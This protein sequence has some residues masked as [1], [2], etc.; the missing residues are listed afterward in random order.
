MNEKLNEFIAKNPQNYLGY[1]VAGL[2][3][4]DSYFLSG[5]FI[6]EFN[7]EKALELRKDDK[8]IKYYFIILLANEDNKKIKKFYSKYK[9][10]LNEYKFLLMLEIIRFTKSRKK[11]K[12]IDIGDEKGYDYLDYLMLDILQAKGSIDNQGENYIYKS[13]SDGRKSTKL[14]EAMFLKRRIPKEIVNEVFIEKYP[15]KLVNLSNKSEV[16]LWILDRNLI[17]KVNN[18]NRDLVQY[19]ILRNIQHE[20][21]HMLIRLYEDFC[22]KTDYDCEFF[23]ESLSYQKMDI[24]TYNHKFLNYY[25]TLKADVYFLKTLEKILS[26]KAHFYEKEVQV[27][28]RMKDNYLMFKTKHIYKLN[29]DIPINEE[30]IKVSV[31]FKNYNI[32]ENFSY[33][34]G[35][36]NYYFLPDEISYITVTL[37][38]GIITINKENFNVQE[39]TSNYERKLYVSAAQYLNIH[40]NSRKENDR[41]ALFLYFSNP[42]FEISKFNSILYI[43]LFNSNKMFKNESYYEIVKRVFNQRFFVGFDNDILHSIESEYLRLGLSPEAV[44]AFVNN[45]NNLN[46]GIKLVLKA[47]QNGIEIWIR[48]MLLLVKKAL[49]N[50][51]FD[52]SLAIACE[53]F[54]YKHAVINEDISNYLMN[55]YE[56]LSIHTEYTKK[57]IEIINTYIKD[58]AKISKLNLS[59][60]MHENQYNY[61]FYSELQRVYETAGSDDEIVYEAVCSMLHHNTINYDKNFLEMIGELYKKHPNNYVL[62]RHF[63]LV[64]IDSNNL[65]PRD[66]LNKLRDFII[67]S[68]VI[69]SEVYK[70]MLYM[71]D[72]DVPGIEDYVSELFK[73]EILHSEDL[74][75]GE[76]FVSSRSMDSL[77]IFND[78]TDREFCVKVGYCYDFKVE[79]SE[80][81]AQLILER[82]KIKKY[83]NKFIEWFGIV[84][85]NEFRS[86]AGEICVVNNILDIK[87][88]DYCFLHNEYFWDKA[89]VMLIVE[90]ALK[91]K[92]KTMNYMKKLIDSLDILPMELMDAVLKM[93]H[94]NMVHTAKLIMTTKNDMS[95]EKLEYTIRMVAL[96]ALNIKDVKALN[97]ILTGCLDNLNNQHWLNIYCSYVKIL[98]DVGKVEYNVILKAF[99]EIK[100]NRMEEEFIKAL[101]EVNCTSFM[102]GS[103]LHQIYKNKEDK[104]IKEL[105]MNILIEYP[106][107]C[108]G[109]MVSEIIQYFG[110]NMDFKNQSKFLSFADLCSKNKSLILSIIDIARKYLQTNTE[111]SRMLLKTVSGESEDAKL[112]FDLTSESKQRIQNYSIDEMISSGNFGEVY[113]AYNLLNNNSAYAL[114]LTDA[115][116]HNLFIQYFR[117]VKPQVIIEDRYF[118]FEGIKI[119]D[120]VKNSDLKEIIKMAGSL[121]Y[122]ES[123][124]F[125]NN[126][127]IKSFNQDQFIISEGA[128]IPLNIID[129]EAV[130]TN[131]SEFMEEKVC[132][133]LTDFILIMLSWPKNKNQQHEPIRKILK[134]SASIKSINALSI[135][136]K[137]ILSCLENNEQTTSFEPKK[138]IALYSILNEKQKIRVLEYMIE[139]DIYMESLFESILY[140]NVSASVKLFYLVNYCSEYSNHY[141][142]IIT[143]INKYHEEN[144][145]IVLSKEDKNNLIIF[146]RRGIKQCELEDDTIIDILAIKLIDREDIYSLSMLIENKRN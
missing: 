55:C 12:K 91:D 95:T 136:L 90:F 30:E 53:L 131:N 135:L 22:V 49:K 5:G 112:T 14:I 60:L 33:I 24:D 10:D 56:E 127:V 19:A 42:S 23:I 28:G 87:I 74:P 11:Y 111:F 71:L 94:E 117:S 102:F 76:L 124:L 66:Y 1:F 17:K 50:K 101:L 89:A 118:V 98:K 61:S 47:Q 73:Y 45:E 108:S 27:L 54:I 57:S 58:D 21:C 138:H 72:K 75:V 15:D 4:L 106:E 82:S 7:M 83:Y 144:P 146:L 52:A 62:L 36:E 129:G 16:F 48:T 40:Y 44:H 69:N 32:K 35:V 86:F 130:N 59:N 80:N 93:C 107:N 119:V 29:I 96:K 105:Y 63:V 114:K 88:L 84:E 37:N 115:S 31:S 104:R 77:R 142:S 18:K 26:D 8:I 38:K 120:A 109:S 34:N 134:T 39:V 68:R 125:K 78:G 6:T 141:K 137:D 140:S 46:D 143:V 2:M 85:N 9:R 128:V 139:N 41:I 123:I 70:I 92:K 133:M 81:Q 25:Y 116:M 97:I 20:R 99:G 100:K 3:E 51:K 64:S 121:V 145:E 132:T 110:Y 13:L 79:N 126:L 65:I 43:S 113:R 122:L 103:L 67:T